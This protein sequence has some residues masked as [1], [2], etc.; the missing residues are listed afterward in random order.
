MHIVG[1]IIKASSPEGGLMEL[2]LSCIDD[3]VFEQCHQ[4]SSFRKL[5]MGCHCKQCIAL[6]AKQEA[7]CIIAFSANV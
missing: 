3:R 6:L 2:P 4:V 7:I 1:D 5:K